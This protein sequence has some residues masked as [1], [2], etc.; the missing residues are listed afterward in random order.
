MLSLT[1]LFVM[2][3]L[4]GLVASWMGLTAAR[5]RAVAQASRLCGEHDIQLLDQSVA[6]SALRLYRHDGHLGVEVRY[7][8]EVSLDGRT[9]QRGQIW[10]RGRRVARL[11]MPEREVSAGFSRARLPRSRLWPAAA[12]SNAPAHRRRQHRQ[13]HPVPAQTE[14]PLVRVTSPPA[15]AAHRAWDG[16]RTAA[17]RNHHRRRCH[18]HPRLPPRNFR[19]PGTSCPDR[20]PARTAPAQP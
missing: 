6:L 18:H 17:A 13:R 1:D 4:C 16:R 11:M 2:L 7:G 9:R 5:E 10:M 3:L 19:R 8:F 20:F 15:D 12:A 14:R